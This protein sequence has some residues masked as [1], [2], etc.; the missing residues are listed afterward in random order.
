MIRL[1]KSEATVLRKNADLQTELNELK[2]FLSGSQGLSFAAQS[3]SQTQPL[4]PSS[5][6]DSMAHDNKSMSKFV[7]VKFFEDNGVLTLG[8]DRNPFHASHPLSQVRGSA[9]NALDVGGIDLNGN[10]IPPPPPPKNKGRVALVADD[11][12]TGIEFVLRWVFSFQ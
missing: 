8:M 9:T 1:R 7:G 10:E 2:Q 11:V 12:Q 3:G 6:N 4:M 5:F